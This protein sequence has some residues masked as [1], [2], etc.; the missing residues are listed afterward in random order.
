H[1]VGTK[2]VSIN[3]FPENIFVYLFEHELSFWYINY[4]YWNIRQDPKLKTIGYVLFMDNE[5]SYRVSFS[6]LQSE[7]KENECVFHCSTATCKFIADS[8]EFSE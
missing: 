3:A 6:W 5:N 7:F 8:G 4:D 1:S 2:Q